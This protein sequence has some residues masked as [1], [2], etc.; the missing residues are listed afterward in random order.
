MS[1][2]KYALDLLKKFHIQNFKPIASPVIQNQKF[3]KENGATKVENSAYRSLIMNLLYLC[4]SR[5]YI[6]F[7]VS[8]LSRFMMVAFSYMKEASWKA[9]LV[10]I[11]LEVRM[12]IRVPQG[13]YFHFVWVHF[14]GIQRNK[15]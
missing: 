3:E 7:T 5:P 6:M 8:L 12:T 4:A 15:L 13:T 2:K 9:I 11:M 10:V 1:Q 14:H